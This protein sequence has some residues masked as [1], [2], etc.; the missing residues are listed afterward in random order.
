MR[1]NFFTLG[2]RLTAAS[3]YVRENS[4]LADIGCDHALL[5]VY[6]ALQGRIRLAYACD[7]A[8][9]PLEKAKEAIMQYGVAGRVVPLLTNGLKGLEDKGITDITVCGMGGELAA[10]ILKRADFVKNPSVRLIFQPMRRSFVL[11]EYLLLSGFNI[12]SESLCEE[13]GRVYECFC[14]HWSGKKQPYEEY[15]L[16]LGLRGDNDN[17]KSPLMRRLAASRL[18]HLD[19]LAKSGQE[20]GELIKSIM[21]VLE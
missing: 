9:K 5:P 13:D 10:E 14:A 18:R 11:R 4:V 3:S 17:Y 20:R 16:W 8:Q 6:L 7:V 2:A 1:E 15:E 19:N 12:I 21:S